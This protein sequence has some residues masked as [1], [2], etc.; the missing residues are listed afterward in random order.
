A[1]YRD[2]LVRLVQRPCAG[3]VLFE[4]PPRRHGRRSTPPAVPGL[5][6]GAPLSRTGSDGTRAQD[7]PAQVR[8][9][10]KPPSGALARCTCILTAISPV[11]LRE[12]QRLMHP[13][14]SGPGWANLAA[15]GM[16]P[17][18]YRFRASDSA[19]PPTLDSLGLIKAANLLVTETLAVSTQAGSGTG[20]STVQTMAW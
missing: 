10:C 11:R 6:R 15:N 19:G 13:G 7:E 2:H 12:H 17:A 9:A 5:D 16:S 8:Q 20:W 18:Q 1:P 4:D 3:A 14:W